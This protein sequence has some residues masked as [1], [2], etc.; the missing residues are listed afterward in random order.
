MTHDWRF[1][2]LVKFAIEMKKK[3]PGF[4]NEIHAIVEMAQDEIES[5][6]SPDN[7]C[8]LA[9]QELKYILPKE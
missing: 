5:G 9:I 1:N 3:H 2:D 4:V 7:E 8:D 6:G